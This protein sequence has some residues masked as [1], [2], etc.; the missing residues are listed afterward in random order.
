MWHC[1]SSLVTAFT[2]KTFASLLLQMTLLRTQRWVPFNF[3]CLK[4][5]QDVYV[6]A[7]LKTI[8]MIVLTSIMLLTM[9]T[10]CLHDEGD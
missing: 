3:A 6:N 8:I 7:L 9:M 10:F 1:P 5:Y 4:L 2:T